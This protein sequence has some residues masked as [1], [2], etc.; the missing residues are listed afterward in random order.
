MARI[1]WNKVAEDYKNS[2]FNQE[3][4]LG[5]AQKAAELLNKNGIFYDG[6]TDDD[7]PSKGMFEKAF[8]F[9]LASSKNKEELIHQH[10]GYWVL[11]ISDEEFHHGFRETYLDKNYRE[12]R[13]KMFLGSAIIR[14]MKWILL[15][16][17]RLALYIYSQTYKEYPY[18]SGA[19]SLGAL[20]DIGSSWLSFL[21]NEK[22]HEVKITNECRMMT[23]EDILLLDHK[24]RNVKKRWVKR[25]RYDI[26]DSVCIRTNNYLLTGKKGGGC[27]KK[28]TILLKKYDLL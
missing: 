14:K 19:N 1:D 15:S 17:G 10:I 24:K 4:L 22:K 28:I 18:E 23:E 2:S 20:R 25:D 6:Y 7:C 27:S 9:L 11:E 13:T 26:E 12:K 21:C 16:D 8:R 3:R 5:Y